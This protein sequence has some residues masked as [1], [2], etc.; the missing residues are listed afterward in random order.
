[1]DKEF[2]K[3]QIKNSETE[4]NLLAGIFRYPESL[5]EIEGF[6]SESDFFHSDWGKF[7]ALFKYL[8]I[9]KQITKLDYAII[10][11]TITNL[12]YK[13]SPVLNVTDFIQKLAKDSSSIELKTIHELATNVILYSRRR[14]VWECGSRMQKRVMEKNF[15]SQ[16]E[17]I[18][19]TDEVYFDAIH[20]FAVE[21]DMEQ[22]GSGAGEILYKRADNPVA[23]VGFSSG[24]DYFDEMIG[25]LR[26]DM[27]AFVLAR[28]KV[29]KSIFGLN[30]AKHVAENEKC[31]VLLMDSEMSKMEVRDRL[32]ANVSQ[33]DINLI[34][35]GRWRSDKIT[36]AKVQKAIAIV[37][38]LNI[39]YLSIRG[40]SI[41]NIMT[42]VR[43]F[44]FKKV[45]R[46]RNGDFNKCFIVYDYLK[47]D[48][49]SNLGD[50]WSLNVAK[51]VV[52][53]K[54]FL[55]STHATALVLGQMNRMGIAKFDSKTNKT[56]VNDSEENVGL[57]DEIVKTASNASILR[58]KTDEEKLE[59]GLHN[60]NCILKPI[61]VR[62]GKGAQWIAPTEGKWVQD[63]VSLERNAECMTF[64]QRETKGRILKSKSISNQV[65]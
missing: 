12:G 64:E 37:E 26:P 59:D 60:G 45:R 33:V 53:F 57:T 31:P 42:G 49:N 65:K 16:Q 19:A 1:M 7:Y 55:G 5:Y 25:N 9:D 2:G 23:R 32:I 51:S 8:I 34:E 44:M 30:V 15:T 38:S 22:L 61:I 10:L 14:E 28:A 3:N 39:E 62:H 40:Q 13:F 36:C 56:I 6:L 41:D 58:Y 17:I 47:L 21:N 29:G 20:K 24:Y 11:A 63:Y 46:D 18:E 50:N 43:R 4:R 27:M 54:D 35:T 48:Y 52:N